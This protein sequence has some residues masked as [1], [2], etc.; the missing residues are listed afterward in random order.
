[1]RENERVELINEASI[2]GVFFTFA[3]T[4]T[5]VRLDFLSAARAFLS[6]VI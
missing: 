3:N 4:D 1:M 2:V 5:D 6:N